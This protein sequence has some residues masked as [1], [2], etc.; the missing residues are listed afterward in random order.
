VSLLSESFD[1]ECEVEETEEEYVEFLEAR[2]GSLEDLESEEESL[3]F[4]A[5]LVESPVVFP[6]VGAIGLW[7]GQLGSGMS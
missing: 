7:R 6:W 4:V 1:D 2:E 5:L 3:D